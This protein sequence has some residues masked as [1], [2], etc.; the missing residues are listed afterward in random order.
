MDNGKTEAT[1]NAQV[2]PYSSGGLR[3]L[4]QDARGAAS[5]AKIIDVITYLTARD[6]V[7]T[8]LTT[9]DRLG[10][11]SEESKGGQT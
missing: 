8:G 4:T 11:L 2:P 1:G 3:L 9:W 10:R 6:L 5:T 7:A